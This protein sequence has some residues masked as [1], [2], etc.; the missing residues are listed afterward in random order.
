L[1]QPHSLD[2][3]NLYSIT[4][5]RSGEDANTLNHSGWRWAEGGLLSPT[6]LLHG[7]PVILI[8]IEED[9]RNIGAAFASSPNLPAVIPDSSFIS[10]GRGNYSD[11]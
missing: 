7:N 9:E 4:N 2:E 11:D 5:S 6:R 10:I 1:L 3:L 8:Y